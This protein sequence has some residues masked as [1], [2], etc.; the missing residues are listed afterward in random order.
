MAEACVVI[1]C[2]QLGSRVL[3]ALAARGVPVRG[4]TRS[5]ESRDRLASRG[6]RVDALDLDDVEALRRVLASAVQVVFTAAP[7]RGGDA[8]AVYDRGLAN[9]LRALDGHDLARVLYTSSTGVYAENRG[10]WVDEN[11]ALDTT[12][13]R[14]SSLVAAERHLLEAA[15][16]GRIRAAALRCSGLVGEGRG[17]QRI[18]G[19]IAGSARSDG[20]AWLNLVSLDTVVRTVLAAL[21]HTW[22]GVVNV[23]SSTPL[24]RR[25]F[26]DVL[27]E[28]AGLAPVEWSPTPPNA[29]LGR[30]VGV[31]RLPDE[32]GIDPGSVDPRTLDLD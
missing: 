29:P 28:R 9:V 19:S 10:A 22:S 8:A 5:V 21:E 17:P 32:L 23:S 31:D 16:E 24:R 18:L 27:L 11:S 15:Q 13:P 3:E 14:T 20:A 25:E 1:G 4:T 30:R 2:G 12:T 6:F 7:G 26:Y